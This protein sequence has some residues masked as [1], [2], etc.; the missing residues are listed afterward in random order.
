MMLHVPEVL[1]PDEVRD[2]RAAMAAGPWVNGASTAGSQA[3]QAK[4]N[5]QLQA[6][7]ALAQHLGE[8]IRAAL[9]RHPLFV[10]AALPQHVLSPMFNAY[11]DGG[12]YGSHVDS[13][14]HVECRYGAPG[15]NR[16]VHHGFL[17]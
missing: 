14:I 5:L 17:V 6:D 13:A 3:V 16:C 4:H 15:Q 9:L 10:S 12:S 11:T 8:K 7:S 2:I 1:T